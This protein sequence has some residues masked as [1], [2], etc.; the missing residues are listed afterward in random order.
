VLG[1]RLPVAGTDYTLNYRSDRAEAWS[2]D[3]IKVQLTEETV[4][5]SLKRVELRI[6]V[7][8]V[9]IENV[10]A[11]AP[12]L[13]YE[14]RWNG[15]DAYGRPL[16]GRYWVNFLLSY[17]YPAEYYG[18]DAFPQSFARFASDANIAGRRDTGEIAISV[19]FSELV[20]AKSLILDDVGG[21]A[22]DV[23]HFYDFRNRTLYLGDGSQRRSEVLAGVGKVANASGEYCVGGYGAPCGDG[24]SALN[25]TFKHITGLAV[26]QDG[27]LFVAD[28]GHGRVRRILPNGTIVNAAGVGDG[29]LDGGVPDGVRV[30]AVSAVLNGREGLDVAV[31]PDGSLYIAEAAG[32]RVNRVRPDGM[33]ERVAGKWNDDLSWEFGCGGRIYYNP[34]SFD[35]EGP[36]IQTPLRCPSAIAVAP[37]NALYVFE[38]DRKLLRVVRD[39]RI[40]T[41]AGGGTC[42]ENNC[43]ASEA[44]LTGL[45]SFALMEDGSIV[46]T[47]EDEDTPYRRIGRI[48]PSG[49]VETIA[50]RGSRLGDDADGRPAVE[51]ALQ[52][53]GGIAVSREGDI[54]FVDGDYRYARPGWLRAIGPD[55]KLKSLAGGE[56]RNF[57]QGQSWDSPGASVTSKRLAVHPDGRVFYIDGKTGVVKLDKQQV[58]IPANGLAVASPDGSEV[59]VFDGGGFHLRTLDALTGATRYEFEYMW[60]GQLIGIVDV[61]GRRT[62]IERDSSG[63]P[64]AIVAPFGQ[65]TVVTLN[66]VMLASITNPMNERFEFTYAPGGLLTSMKRPRGGLST[67][68]YDADRRLIRD[69]NPIGGEM[70]LAKSELG[71]EEFG[72]SVTITDTLGKVSR[73]ETRYFPDE[74]NPQEVETREFAP[75]G[76]ETTSIRKR[77]GKRITINP[78]GTVITTTL[79]PD[80]RFGM[81]APY[82]KSRVVGDAS[83]AILYQMAA[84]RTVQLAN[85]DNP[86]SLVMLSHV[87]NE[88][89]RMS[90]VTYTASSRTL[91]HVDVDGV[92][93]VTVLDERG[94]PVSET[95]SGRAPVTFTRDSLGRIT[96][97]TEGTGAEARTTTF[98]FGSNGKVASFTDALGRT[99]RFTYDLAGRETRRELPLGFVEERAYDADGNLIRLT[100]ASGV[101]TRYQY[102][103]AGRRTASVVDPDGLAIRTEYRYDK[104][105]NLVEIIEDAGSGRTNATTRLSY[106]P[107]GMHTYQPSRIVDPVG[108]TTL[109][110]YTVTGEVRAITDPSGSTT[111]YFYDGADRLT[112]ATSS[113]GRTFRWRYNRNGLVEE[114][115]DPSGVTTRFVYDAAGRITSVIEGA[116]AVGSSPAINATTQFGYDASGRMA[117]ITD[118]LGRV[119]TRTFDSFGRL[120]EERDPLNNVTR[121]DYDKVDRVTAVSFGDNVPAERRKV[122]Y[123][124]D[125][126]GRRVAQTIDPDG[127][128]LRTEYR[129]SRAGSSDR[130]GLQEVVDPE[131]GVTVYTYNSVGWLERVTDALGQV[132]QFGYNT[133]GDLVRQVDPLGRETTFT[134][135]AKGQR[136]AV[137]EGTAVE[138]WSYR[139]DGQV[140]S[141][142]DFAGQQ[143]T[144]SY[145][146]DGR[147]VGISYPGG[148]PSVSLSYDGAGRRTQMTDGLG[149]TTYSYDALG[150]MVSRSR[151]GRTVT[152]QYDAASQLTSV[153]YWGRGTVAYQFDAASRASSLAPWGGGDVTFGWSASH[154]LKSEGR[155]GGVNTTHTYDG[156]G[157]RTRSTTGS[158]LDLQYTLDRRNNRLAMTDNDGTTEFQYDALSRLTQVRYPAVGSLPAK[159]VGYQYD[160]V[161][162]RTSESVTS[163]GTTTRAFS[164]DGRNRITNPGYQ[165]D[166]NGNLLSDG[167]NSYS[168]DGANRLTQSVVVSGTQVITTTYGYDGLGNLVRQ[169]INGVTSDLV[170]DERGPLAFILGEVRSDGVEILY[171]HGPNGLAAQKRFEGGV[172]QGVEYALVDPFGTVRALVDG[173]GIVRRRVSYLAFGQV[174]HASGPGWSTLGFLGERM[175]E[176]DGTLYLR[177][178]V[179]NPSHGR[180][181]QRDV[182]RGLEFRPQSL[183]RYIYAENNPVRFL[184]RSGF[185]ADEPQRG[186]W[187]RA[188]DW[189]AG[190]SKLVGGGPKHEYKPSF[191]SGKP[192]TK[193]AVEIKPQVTDA[194]DKRTVKGF[195]CLPIGPN[196]YIPV[197][198]QSTLTVGEIKV[199]PTLGYDFGKGFAV[200]KETGQRKY[201]EGRNATLG[202][203]F[204]IVKLESVATYGTENFGLTFGSESKAS[205]VS[206]VG[207]LKDGVLAAQATANIMSEALKVGVNIW[208]VNIALK[209]EIGAK[210]EWGVKVG[211]SVELKMPL[212]SVGLEIGPPPPAPKSSGCCD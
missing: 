196:T 133:R 141:Y 63:Y 114:A 153:D 68:A 10:Y 135:D 19:N 9:V 95:R 8:G 78:N 171:A 6:S 11:P 40:T 120:V 51:A 49:D 103:L 44:D 37:D 187:E 96:S 61:H 77:D 88:N 23:H 26:G 17:V 85:P 48:W 14:F 164:Y 93:T 203:E 59:F 148:L 79:A 128:A 209:G 15:L 157:R 24:G 86:F 197:T 98:T 138:R 72:S 140:A 180:F 113:L 89:G 156:A 16:K 147:L 35:E 58:S 22:F 70:R 45:S 163:S 193:Y 112:Q 195:D 198:S 155:P 211:K 142:T 127:L 116:A 38:Y 121:M 201:R 173:G 139:P 131:G 99:V 210:M 188:F 66:G 122:A 62:R 207:G 29:W 175:G 106:V 134:V 13:K 52:S 144:L 182:F 20:E 1:E 166:A 123:E 184:D 92:Q 136:T 42:R 12:K 192:E 97:I 178:R 146:A 21:W 158:L 75:N 151:S 152:Y 33:M 71:F 126:L 55:G 47:Q 54:L 161:G 181:L 105:D 115:V 145:D 169:T 30:P 162:N 3:K 119:T 172:G 82:V 108:A 150:R 111:S 143:T 73:F 4:P 206:L 39:G 107:T 100:E 90:Y 167:V 186:F 67:F 183:N 200:D 43:R 46:F 154:E 174:R 60:N 18:P 212:Y 34:S 64:T 160:A 74:S 129:Y 132:W 137:Q 101:T 28:G 53:A 208:G 25:A 191:D 185:A 124:Y 87:M 125:A 94:R 7:M 81:S 102:D 57:P 190:H 41:F 76:A 104:A 109:I 177:A 168:Y 204:T 194:I 130:F 56:N 170:I 65:R 202:G 2:R 50:G 176:A 118:P 149:T 189:V 32:N 36:A 5:A 165:Y 91:T 31:A 110:S 80:P 27:G 84:T 117:T 83:G 179:M 199:E 159:E 69:T 205:G